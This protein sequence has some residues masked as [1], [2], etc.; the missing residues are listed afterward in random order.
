[1]PRR[2]PGGAPAAPISITPLRTGSEPPQH[3]ESS[4]DGPPGSGRQRKGRGIAVTSTTASCT[5]VRRAAPRGAQTSTAAACFPW[6]RRRER[7]PPRRRSDT[8]RRERPGP[9]G[10]L[11]PPE[12]QPRAARR[13]P[14][15]EATTT[16]SIAAARIAHLPAESVG[17]EGV[18]S[19]PGLAPGASPK[20]SRLT[21]IVPAARPLTGLPSGREAAE[22]PAAADECSDAARIA[23]PCSTPRHARSRE[24]GTRSDSRGAVT[25]RATAGRGRGN[26]DRLDGGA[27][28]NLTRSAGRAAHALPTDHLTATGATRPA[29][30][31]AGVAVSAPTPAIA[32]RTT[33]PTPGAPA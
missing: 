3:A 31:H 1:M 25:R 12:G 4:R 15:A 11:V 16:F 27:A 29:D 19:S 23:V 14:A 18:A 24:A 10:N 7:G 17:N 20:P 33:A 21:L 28:H 22:L 32:S 2:Q 5:G 6:R 30:L 13:R 9:S 8:Q 26:A